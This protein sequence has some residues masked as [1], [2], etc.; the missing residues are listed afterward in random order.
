MISFANDRWQELNGGIFIARLWCQCAVENN[1]DI[2]VLSLHDSDPFDYAK[3]ERI[4]PESK[5]V[6]VEFSV[7]PQQNNSGISGNRTG[8]CKRNAL[9]A[10][11]I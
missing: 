2:K 7:T 3:A 10:T 11:D 1:N 8:R 9:P 6:A 4:F 5:K